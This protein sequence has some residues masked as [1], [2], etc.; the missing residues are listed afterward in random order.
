MKS[1]SEF[2]WVRERQLIFSFISV[3]DIRSVESNFLVSSGTVR[4]FL[5]GRW[6]VFINFSVDITF[7]AILSSW[8]TTFPSNGPRHK[9]K[10]IS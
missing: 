10:L 5:D 3:Y 4:H 2:L 6:S 8:S 1:F 9:L 7:M